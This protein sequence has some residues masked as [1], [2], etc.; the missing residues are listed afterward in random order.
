M[1]LPTITVCNI[2]DAEHL[3][4]YIPSSTYTYIE[5]D[6]LPLCIVS[7]AVVID[8]HIIVCVFFQGMVRAVLQGH[9]CG[10]S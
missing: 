3:N 6:I 7:T 2:S 8:N 5:R 9:R 10:G 1:P 4:T